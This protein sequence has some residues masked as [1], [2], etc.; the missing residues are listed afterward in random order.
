[1][2]A[3]TSVAHDAAISPRPDSAAAVPGLAP[4]ARAH[5]AAITSHRDVDRHATITT[6]TAIPDVPPASQESNISASSSA[7]YVPPLLS[8]QSNLSSESVVETELTSPA[9][10]NVS[11]QCPPSTQSAGVPANQEDNRPP[12]A[13]T[14]QPATT[15]DDGDVNASTASPMAVDTPTISYGTKRT[16][17]GAVKLPSSSASS[18]SSVLFSNERSRN[19]SASSNPSR[20]GQLS[21]DLKTRLSYAMMKVQHGWEQKSLDELETA[22]ASQRTSPATQTP[23]SVKFRNATDSPHAGTRE[24]ARHPDLWAIEWVNPCLSITGRSDLTI[25]LLDAGPGDFD[26][27]DDDAR[28]STASTYSSSAS[29]APTLAA[30]LDVSPKRHR[31]SISSRPPPMLGSQAN[32]NMS[33]PFTNVGTPSTPTPGKP[34]RPVGILR[35]PSQQAEMDAVDSLL[36]MSS[37]NNSAHLAHTGASANSTA[38]PSPLRTEFPVAKRVAFD[39]RSS[40]NSETERETNKSS[41]LARVVQAASSEIRERVATLG[42]KAAS[43]GGG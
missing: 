4:P 12:R 6:S 10:S 19:T 37:P 20:I 5:P 7:S 16:A 24:P 39:D 26:A 28:P 25:S 23:T 42:E 2:E 34:Q 36:F 40:S 3:L 30:V 29:S 38:H 17:S 1:M 9:T 31:R 21:A 13:V 11:S 14:P 15:T 22:A 27:V 33:K 43:A 8:S 32:V 41:K 18:R 35:M